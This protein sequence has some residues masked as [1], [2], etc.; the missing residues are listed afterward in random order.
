M[1]PLSNSDISCLSGEPTPLYV[2]AAALE[3][4]T[5][6]PTSQSIINNMTE[7]QALQINRSVRERGWREVV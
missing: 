2:G 1:M 4:A 5:D 6:K 7:G 3:P